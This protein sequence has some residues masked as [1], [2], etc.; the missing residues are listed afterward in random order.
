MGS[1]SPQ[2]LPGWSAPQESKVANLHLLGP[3]DTSRRM[4]VA[5]C[6]TRGPDLCFYRAED[7][8]CL[9]GCGTRGADG[10]FPSP[11]PPPCCAA[12]RLAFPRQGCSWRTMRLHL[13]FTSNKLPMSEAT[14]SQ[15]LACGLPDWFCPETSPAG[16]AARLPSPSVI[17]PRTGESRS[18]H[19]QSQQEARLQHDSGFLH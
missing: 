12:T 3:W 13:V 16:P 1:V 9:Q 11:R 4:R 7:M 5:R 17:R 19:G 15:R 6:A 8:L 18:P 10:S 2:G 14:F